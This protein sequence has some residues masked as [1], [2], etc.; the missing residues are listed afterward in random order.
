M[1]GVAVRVDDVDE[2]HVQLFEQRP[3]AA[4][5]FVDAVDDHRFAAIRITKQIAIGR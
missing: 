5:L 3:V 2:V 4:H 1:V